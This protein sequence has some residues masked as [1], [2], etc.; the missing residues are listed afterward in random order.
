LNQDFV[1]MLSALREVR[2]EFLVVGAHALAVHGRPRAT[3][4]LDLWVRPSAENAARVWRA[5]ADFGAPL[6]SITVDDLARPDVV[7]KIGVAPRRIDIL[8]SI[9]G[10]EFS[11]AWGGRLTV[12]IGD[13]TVPVLGRAALIANKRAVGRL[14]DL[15]DLEAL[16][17]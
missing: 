16:G 6:D 3:G 11:D 8:A 15:A 2:A 14:Q 1:A 7:F 4:D 10:V 12:P 17:E 9:S 13:L 5:L